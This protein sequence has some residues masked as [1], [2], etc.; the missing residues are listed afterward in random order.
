MNS[1]FQ[2]FTLFILQIKMF[3][4]TDI[5]TGIVSTSI[6]IRFTFEQNPKNGIELVMYGEFNYLIRM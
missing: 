3:Y 4:Q 5:K 2:I 1:K 6:G